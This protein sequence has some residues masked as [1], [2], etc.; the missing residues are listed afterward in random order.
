MADGG[1]ALTTSTT[2]DIPTANRNQA[3]VPTSV[4]EN[5]LYASHASARPIKIPHNKS[6]I[7]IEFRA[8]TFH[9]A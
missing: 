4:D 6:L 7:V 8:D 5:V 1:V 9:T 3:G 2:A